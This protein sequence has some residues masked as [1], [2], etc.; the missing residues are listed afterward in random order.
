MDAIYEQLI[1]TQKTSIYSACNMLVYI[2]GGI[3]LLS[4]G[5]NILIA[6]PFIVIAA[7][8]YFYKGNFYLE[9]QYDFINGEID[10]DKIIEMKKR[11]KVISFNIKQVELLAL[12]N[13]DHVKDYSKA[14]SKTISALSTTCSAKVYNAYIFQDNQVVKLRFAPDEKFLDLCYKYNPRVVKKY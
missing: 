1:T 8:L 12:E 14:A 7:A 9:F 2:I 4:T 5:V 6:I 11:K 10:V 3:G 13:S